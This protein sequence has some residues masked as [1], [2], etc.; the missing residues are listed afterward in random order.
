MIFNRLT[1]QTEH[2]FISTLYL[3]VLNK[4]SPALNRIQS[5]VTLQEGCALIRTTSALCE[6]NDVLIATI[7]SY[8]RLEFFEASCAG[9]VT[10]IEEIFIIKFPCTSPLIAHSI[11]PVGNDKINIQQCS[12]CHQGSRFNTKTSL[13][14]QV[15][16]RYPLYLIVSHLYKYSNLKLVFFIYIG[17]D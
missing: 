16:V 2:N 13:L 17:I 3:C 7:K 9:F 11:L 10:S 15:F 1:A 8:H 12:T 6:L 4:E 5:C 14:K